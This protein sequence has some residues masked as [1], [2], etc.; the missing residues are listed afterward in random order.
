M[1][2]YQRNGTGLKLSTSKYCDQRESLA[3]WDDVIPIPRLSFSQAACIIF[4]LA[5]L[6]F[7]NSYDGDFV[8]DDSEAVTGNKDLNPQTPLADLFFHD[9]WGRKLDSKTSHKSYR[10]LTVLTFRWNYL[11]A[12]GLYPMGFHIMNIILHGVVSVLVLVTC[13]VLLS[14]CEIRNGSHVFGCPKASFLCAI[15]FAVHPVHT[16]SVAAVVGRADLMCA[17]FFI[18]SFL[19]YIKACLKGLTDGRLH[20]PAKVS[21]VWL[22]A[23]MFLCC[24][25][26]LCK[27]QGI[28]VIGICCAYDVISICQIDLL[29]VPGMIFKPKKVQ[30]TDSK[31]AYTKPWQRYLACR[32]LFLLISG[33][34]ILTVRWRMMGSATPTFQVFDN[35]HSFVNGSLY[36]AINYIY[37]YSINCWLLIHPWWLCFDWSMGCIPVIESLSDWRIP[38]VILFLLVVSGLLHT[39]LCGTFSYQ[40][41][42]ITMALAFIIVPFLPAMNIF[43]RVGFVIAE[44]VLYLP[45][46]GF[47]ILVVTGVSNLCQNKERREVVRYCMYYLVVIFMLRSIHRSDQWRQEM[48]LFLSGAKVC[49]LNAKVHYNIAK[50]NGDSGNTE[51]AIE[52]Y[53]L[54]IRLNSEYD[55]AMNNLGNILK[56]KGQ[57]Q[58]AEQLLLK[59]VKIRDDFAAAWMN[60]GI[61]QAALHKNSS[62]EI[63]Y[64]T[65]IKHRR[66]YPDCYYNLGNLYLEMGKHHLAIQAFKN[67]TQQKPDHVNAWGNMVILMDNLGYTSEAERFGREA[68]QYSKD[69]TLL[70]NL[71]NILGKQDKFQESEKYFLEAVKG[72]N[73]DPRTYA[74]LGVLYHRWGKYD[75]A[76]KAY[77][78]ALE[79][80]SS[81]TT[82]RDNLNMVLRK[83]ERMGK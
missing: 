69:P 49:P 82:T 75:S 23:S 25:S 73:D 7:A 21:W 46:I 59:A 15:L 43:F 45:S 68:L 65:A 51:V 34:I 52:K 4:C 83:M 13:S 32:L 5:I 50:L 60:L 20:Q 55:Q 26:V 67:A 29:A 63:S 14:G 1:N 18:L 71:A 12:G 22:V 47:C 77:N 56:E 36:R 19:F 27:E 70:L 37:L 78:K 74:N 30:D 6:C 54:A 58:E 3:S 79:L 39:S 61:V 16:E 80:D 72:K 9:F 42:I 66:R 48:P 44:R 24:A 57:L 17:I 28:T 53:R 35:P 31:Q 11:L 2:R 64:Y 62:A 81:L 33:L 41:K 10:P 40:K 76:V 8:F 38:F